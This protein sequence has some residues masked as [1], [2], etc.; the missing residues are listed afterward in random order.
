MIKEMHLVN[1]RKEKNKKMA[2][3]MFED[4]EELNNEKL[5][6]NIEKA[7]NSKKKYSCYNINIEI[8]RKCNFACEHL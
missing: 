5:F 1:K 2:N 4:Y 6:K 3:R 7:I 8:T